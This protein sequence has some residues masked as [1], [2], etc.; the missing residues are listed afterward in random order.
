M[1]EERFLCTATP[2]QTVMQA[3]LFQG[4]PYSR[5]FIFKRIN[6]ETESHH[7]FEYKNL[8]CDV[9]EIQ[10]ATPDGSH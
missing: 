10:K 8:I 7:R 1:N 6:L 9:R 5:Y 3:L 2:S 4:M